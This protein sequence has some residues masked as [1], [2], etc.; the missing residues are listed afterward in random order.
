MASEPRM[1]NYITAQDRFMSVFHRSLELS[2]AL[3][4]SH[5]IFNFRHS[6][7]C[8]ATS[9]N[10]MHS[11]R[12]YDF[13]SRFSVGFTMAIENQL[14]KNGNEQQVVRLTMYLSGY[15]G[16]TEKLVFVYFMWVKWASERTSYH[17]TQYTHT[18]Y[19]SIHLRNRSC[20]HTCII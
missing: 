17:R 13:F 19:P 12:V 3:K 14:K 16:W 15:I 9:K 4:W 1:K 7:V 8:D 18:Q 6:T 20:Y 5:C 11:N 10:D 2:N